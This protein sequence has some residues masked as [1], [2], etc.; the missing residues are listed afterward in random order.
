MQAIVCEKAGRLITA[1]RPVPVPAAGEA[2]IR[3]R[4]I[5]VCGTDLHAYQGNQPYFTYPRVLGHE[6]AGVVEAVAPEMDREC[7]VI[8]L[9]GKQS[10]LHRGDQVCLIPYL[11]CGSCIACRSGK[12]NCCSKMRVMG[13]HVD[14]GMQEWVTVPLANLIRTNG[15]TLEQTAVME[16]LSIGMH[17][18]RRAD[19]KRGEDVLVIGSG[20]IGLGVMTAAKRRGARVIAMDLSADRLAQSRV[21][22]GTDETVLAGENAE[23]R[24]AELTGG[25]FPTAVFDATGS[26]HSMTAA[27]RYVAH[28]GRLIYVGLVKDELT[29]SDPEFHKREMTLMGSRNAT[30]EDFLLAADSLRSGHANAGEYITH[31]CP[32][33]QAAERFH[34]WTGP[35]AKVQKAM[36]EL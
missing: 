21:W 13:V 5:G 26:R 33:D 17:A 31:R 2:L 32:F 9:D 36:I 16:P 15:L 28:G 6:L 22:A 25:D 34:E 35:T 4:R 10:A 18:V 27:F 29:F 11:H 20:P 30:I 12:T 23:R 24:I 14:G 8:G 1:E 19:L 3:I 7:G